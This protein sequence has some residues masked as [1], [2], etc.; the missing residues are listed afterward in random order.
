MIPG[1]ICD[2]KLFSKQI[3][4]LQHELEISV[5]DHARDLSLGEIAKEILDTVS[6]NFYLLGVSMGGYISFE[7]M[8]Q[9][10]KRGEAWRIKKLVLCST[11]ARLDQ[12][13]MEQRRR[14]FIALA[15]KGKFKGMSPMLMRTFIHPSKLD[16]KK[17]SQTIYDMVETTGSKGFIL[18]TNM[19]LG[20]PDSR[21]SLA[22]INCDTLVICGEDDERTPLYLSE[23]IAQ[24]IPQAKLEIIKQCGHL[25]PLEQPEKLNELLRSF[26][27]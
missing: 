2:R 5:V 11:S 3:E 19:L 4:A 26:L 13:E 12:P 20:R 9:A 24:L 27:L 6:G 23:E 14:D 15:K 7:V 8:R 22:E 18:Q 25:P 17:V 1:L 21:A 16:D 10:K